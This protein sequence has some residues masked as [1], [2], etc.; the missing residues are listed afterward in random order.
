M[1]RG[2]SRFGAGRPGWKGKAEVCLP[3]DIR[4]MHRR[5]CLLPGCSASLRWTWSGTD[6]EAGSIGYSFDGG[7]LRLQYAVDGE[8]QEQRISVVRTP[9]HFGGSR[10]WFRCPVRGERVAVLYLRAGRFACRH[11][12]CIAYLS[13]SEDVVGRSWRKQSKVEKQLGP[14]GERPKGMH[15][16]T[17]ERLLS[18]IDECEGARDGALFLF[19]QRRGWL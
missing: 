19:M 15:A 9:C 12:Q 6:D 18:V 17:Y 2:G 11:C 14:D 7:Y 13:Q 1:G 5:R 16:V 8:G 3:L 10:P 4:A